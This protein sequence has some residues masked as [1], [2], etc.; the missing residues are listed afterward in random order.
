MHLIFITIQV[1]IVI[2]ARCV[3]GLVEIFKNQ[4]WASRKIWVF[5]SIYGG[6]LFC[7]VL[8]FNAT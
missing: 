4:N 7:F 6:F 3:S 2:D 1:K 8:F 5:S